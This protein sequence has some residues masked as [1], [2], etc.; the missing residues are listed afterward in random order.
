MPPPARPLRDWRPALTDSTA[1]GALVLRCAPPAAVML[2]LSPG[3]SPSRGA[4]PPPPPSFRFVEVGQ[5]AGLDFVHLHGKRPLDI[6]RT[7]GS[8]LAWLDFDRDGWPDLFCVNG[9][10][11]GAGRDHRAGHRL[12]RN[13]GDGTFQDVTIRAGLSGR[14]EDGMGASAVD[15][16]ADGSP[17]I[18]ITCFGKNRLYRNRGGGAFEDV[19]V[20]IGLDV[21]SPPSEPNWSTGAAWFDADGDLDL[22]LYVANYCRYGPTARRLC[23]LSGVSSACPP[24][25]YA[26]QDDLFFVNTGEG[27]ERAR[28]RFSRGGRTSGRGLGVL[29]FDAEGDGKPEVFV[30]ND[31]GGNFLFLN[32]GKG[33][34]ERAYESGVALDRAGGD[35]ASMGT[36]A[37]D[38]NGDGRPDLVV[39]NFQDLPNLFYRQEA[40]RFFRE[41]S[42]ETGLAEGTRNVLTFGIGIVDLDLNGQAELLFVNGHVQDNIDKIRR[43]VAW[44]Q[45]PQLFRMVG[46]SFQD[47]SAASGPAFQE[48]LAGRGSAFAD[49]DRDGDEDVAVSVNGGRV[50]LWRNEGERGHWLQVELRGRAPNTHAIGAE[51]SLT[52]GGRRQIR[53]VLS[54]RSYLSDSERVIT[55]GLGAARRFDELRIRWPDGRIQ[56]AVPGDG[57]RRITVIQERA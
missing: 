28:H 13:R 2:W 37:A 15:Y 46:A 6:R 51:V 40:P 47:V 31:G 12:Y 48:A 42:S 18:L 5:A 7:T 24:T 30:A 41:V 4:A 56:S 39:G 35:P 50:R 22:D 11:P 53:Q 55:F 57:D 36:D 43:G 32:E 23:A 21:P 54:G 33:Y 14:G 38:L 10:P 27:F 9:S 52:A 19:T 3:C 29:P 44:E 16:D 17:D 20:R 25:H 26:G 49:Y 8:G 34:V 1:F 45:R